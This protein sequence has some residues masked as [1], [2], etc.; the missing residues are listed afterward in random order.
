MCAM[1]NAIISS[2]NAQWMP[3]SGALLM[4]FL[5]SISGIPHVGHPMVTA[6]QPP[7]SHIKGHHPGV[8]NVAKVLNRHATD[9]HADMAEYF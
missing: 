9:V 5:S 1:R 7:L 4:I 8:A 6:F 3:R 2:V